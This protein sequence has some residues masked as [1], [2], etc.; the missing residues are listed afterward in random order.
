MSTFFKK[1]G[2]LSTDKVDH[3]LIHETAHLRHFKNANKEFKTLN[4]TYKQKSAFTEAERKLINSSVSKY[5]STDPL[6]FIAE[7]YTGLK[8]GIVYDENIMALFE[9]F[10]GNKI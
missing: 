7:T 6:E 4:Q 1:T 9:R 8:D 5:A 10:G 2:V 3:S